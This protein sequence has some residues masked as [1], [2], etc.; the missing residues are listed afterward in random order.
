MRKR[1]AAPQLARDV[2]LAIKM[3]PFVEAGTETIII[4]PDCEPTCVCEPTGLFWFDTFS[5][6][7]SATTVFAY[8]LEFVY[9][10]TTDI[11]YEAKVLGNLCDQEVVWDIQYSG[12]VATAPPLI[13]TV[14]HVLMTSAK[15]SQYDAAS[16]E[17]VKPGTIEFRATVC[18]ITLGPIFLVIV[19]DISGYYGP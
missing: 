13:R 15:Q 4:E 3:Q 8:T 16:I 12:L 17:I 14:D 7:F 2:D 19:E 18:D 1:P 9:T 11:A 10:L 6:T 5:G